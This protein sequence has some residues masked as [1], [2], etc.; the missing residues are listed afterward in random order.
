MSYTVINN[1]L[2]RELD[3][4][5]NTQLLLIHLISYESKEFGYAYPTLPTL[6][7]DTGLSRNTIL[8]C[9]NELE[10]KGYIKRVFGTCRI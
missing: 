5:G 3:V 1:S 4:K 8:K 10:G 2:L 7:K 9:L 6:L